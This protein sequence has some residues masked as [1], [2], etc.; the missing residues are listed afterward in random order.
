MWRS[1]PPRVQDGVGMQAVAQ[2]VPQRPRQSHWLNHL[3]ILCDLV[4][5]V[6]LVLRGRLLCSLTNFIF[7]HPTLFDDVLKLGDGGLNRAQRGSYGLHLFLMLFMG[8]SVGN[9]FQGR[10]H[11]VHLFM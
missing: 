9:S 1:P 2:L 6:R 3:H 11:S 10:R 5:R 8:P 4:P 7:H